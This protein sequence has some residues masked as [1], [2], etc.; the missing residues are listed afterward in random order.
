MWKLSTGK[1]VEKEL[2]KLGQEL[3][4]EQLVFMHE[5]MFVLEK[6]Y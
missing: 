4:F 2:Y 5:I 6:V 3:E 1:F